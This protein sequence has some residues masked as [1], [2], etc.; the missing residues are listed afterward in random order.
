MPQTPV[1]EE[2]PYQP[3]KNPVLPDSFTQIWI[4]FII[5]FRIDPS[6]MYRWFRIGPPQVSLNRLPQEFYSPGILLTI[7]I[8]NEKQQNNIFE[9]ERLILL[10]RGKKGKNQS[11]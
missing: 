10:T 9:I 7:A 6:K 11:L 1:P 8:M 2:Q 4:P 5:G 3:E